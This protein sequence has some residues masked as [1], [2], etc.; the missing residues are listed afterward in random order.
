MRDVHR[1]ETQFPEL[2]DEVNKRRRAG[3]RLLEVARWFSAESEPVDTEC[4]TCEHVDRM[5]AAQAIAQWNAV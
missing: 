4:V 3:N 5:M 1:L 2:V